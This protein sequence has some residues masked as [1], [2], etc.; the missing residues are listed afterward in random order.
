MSTPHSEAH[1]PLLERALAGELAADDPALARQLEG[2]TECRAELDRLRG[3]TDRLARAAAK[4]DEV[5]AEI[6][7]EPI[8]KDE[9]RSV[10]ESLARAGALRPTAPPRTFRLWLVVAA[11]AAALLIAYFAWH[12]LFPAATIQP[13]PFLLEGSTIRD[14][15]PHDRVDDYLEFSWSFQRPPGGYFKV[16]V[17]DA[18]SGADARPIF[19]STEPIEQNTWPPPK[20][21]VRTWPNAIRWRVEAYDVENTEIGRS[22]LQEA[23]RSPH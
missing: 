21:L 4:R 5:L 10:R 2:C 15:A 19:E 22:Q 6:A 14:L 20:E 16:R 12:A 8:A 11:A 9:V 1:E 3:V 13:R 23:S 17:W 7:R 18:G